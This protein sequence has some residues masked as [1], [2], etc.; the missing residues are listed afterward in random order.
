MNRGTVFLDPPLSHTLIHADRDAWEEPGVCK[1][2]EPNAPPEPVVSCA[3]E[4]SNMES[5]VNDRGTL[6]D[7]VKSRSLTSGL[8]PTVPCS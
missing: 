5:S 4:A 6:A 2:V 8:S 7:M 3:G 1:T